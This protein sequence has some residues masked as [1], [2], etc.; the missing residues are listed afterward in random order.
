MSSII[1]IPGAYWAGAIL[2]SSWVHLGDIL[3]SS[4]GH[5][6]REGHPWVFLGHHNL[7]FEL[8]LELDTLMMVAVDDRLFRMRD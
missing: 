8:D 6:S 5:G 2:R 3:G 7:D 1:S 4:W